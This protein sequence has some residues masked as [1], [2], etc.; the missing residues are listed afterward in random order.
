MKRS[1]ACGGAG[2]R[3]CCRWR[4]LPSPFSCSVAFCWR[5]P[6]SIA[7]ARNG[8]GRRRCPCTLT[9]RSRRP[10]RESVERMLAPG[11]VVAS[12]EFVS[13]PE[14]LSRFKTTFADLAGTV[15]ALDGNPLPASY[16]VRLRPSASAAGR[17][18]GAWGQTA[19]SERRGRRSLRSPVAR[20][21]VV[22]SERRPDSR[23]GARR[24]P[25]PGGGS[26][27]GQRRAPGAIRAAR[28]N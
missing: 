10:S 7:W 3:A 9:M 22:G 11:P 19:R 5:H 6:I 14:A 2:G 24:G 15:E 23:L 1:S 25:D 16:E 27:G 17:R 4:P 20:S 8:A 13:K 18:R 28:R 21:A 26:D 12:F